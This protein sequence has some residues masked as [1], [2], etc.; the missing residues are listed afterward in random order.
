[1]TSPMLDRRECVIVHLKGLGEKELV[2]S[3]V[4]K[5][6]SVIR[7]SHV[8]ENHGGRAVAVLQVRGRRSRRRREGKDSVKHLKGQTGVSTAAAC[9]GL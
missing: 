9:T 2:S 8:V 5:R 3:M 6:T 4:L 7:H 1:M